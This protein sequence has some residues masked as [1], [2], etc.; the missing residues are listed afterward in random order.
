M[1]DI[2]TELARQ[3]LEPT[4]ADLEVQT[5]TQIQRHTETYRH[6]HRT[7]QAKV[8]FVAALSDTLTTASRYVKNMFFAFEIFREIFQFKKVFF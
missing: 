5:H 6:M 7:T 1:R 4:T 8:I 3:Q 2:E